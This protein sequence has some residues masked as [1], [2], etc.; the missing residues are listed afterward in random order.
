MAPEVSALLLQHKHSPFPPPELFLLSRRRP[1]LLGVIGQDEARYAWMRII[2]TSCRCSAASGRFQAAG[3]RAVQIAL[4]RGSGRC[5]GSGEGSRHRSFL[6]RSRAASSFVFREPS[7]LAMFMNLHG[8]FTQ[9][10][11]HTP[12]AR[13]CVLCCVVVRV[14]A[15]RSI[16]VR[17]CAICSYTLPYDTITNQCWHMYKAKCRM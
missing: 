5:G 2:L 8:S 14:C 16:D 10:T 15:A 11:C 1:D 12:C 4:K 9:C 3:P 17:K 6:T 7:F 13:N